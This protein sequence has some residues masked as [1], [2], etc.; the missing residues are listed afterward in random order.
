MLMMMFMK[1]LSN[2]DYIYIFI[3]ETVKWEVE[4]WNLSG[5][6]RKDVPFALNRE[7]ATLCSGYMVRLT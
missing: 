5:V 4:Y 2:D 6:C 7:L 1:S 3:F